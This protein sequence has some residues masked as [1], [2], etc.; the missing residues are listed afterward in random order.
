MRVGPVESQNRASE[1][2]DQR[3]TQRLRHKDIIGGNAN[4]P[5]IDEAAPGNAAS[6]HFERSVGSNKGRIFPSK[7]ERHWREVL[8]R[9][10]HND[11]AHTA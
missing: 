1:R 5:G 2:V 9:G 10:L 11:A 4:L 3:E 7:L 8:C 6:G